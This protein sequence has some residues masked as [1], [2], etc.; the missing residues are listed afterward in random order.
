MHRNAAKH[1]QPEPG[2]PFY[3]A[4]VIR[5]DMTK[6]RRYKSGWRPSMTAI[7]PS[8]AG[9]SHRTNHLPPFSPSFSLTLNSTTHGG[10]NVD[11]QMFA[12]VVRLLPVS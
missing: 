9:P 11:A 5:K 7:H 8:L 10:Y 12:G 6:R 2:L 1:V 3:G 4:T